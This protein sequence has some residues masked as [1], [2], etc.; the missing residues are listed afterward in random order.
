MSA[1][2]QAQ[3]SV[4]RLL[5]VLDLDDSRARTTED[6]FTGQ[7]HAMP[8][9]R[10]YG[11][12]VLGQSILAAERTMPTERAAH[13]MHGYFLRPGDAT[14]GITI[15]VDRIHDGR[16]FST[17]RSQAY[18][19][20]VPIF[21]MIASFQDEAPGL[22]HAQPMPAGIP[23]PD[24]LTPDDERLGTVATDATLLLTQR[25]VDIR[26]VDTSLYLSAADE[27][28]PQ[29]TVW[30]RMRAAVPDDPRLHRAALAYLSDMTIQ[31]SILRAHGVSWGTSGLKVASLDHAMWWHRPARVDEWLLYVQE[32]PNARGGRGLAAGRVY[33]RDGIL[34]ASVAQ[35]IMIRVPEH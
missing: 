8:S 23:D 20:G 26:H 12:Q 14:Q 30:M 10:I 1:N 25:P 29:Q 34:V 3:A 4:A 24:D 22:D 5:E 28:A 35:E 32:S 27:R 6:I 11:G 33:T 15:A 17:R 31:E 19:N 7:S 13:S 18:Q 16:S 9:G 21:S 2:A